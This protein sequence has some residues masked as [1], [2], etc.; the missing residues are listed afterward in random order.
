MWWNYWDTCITSERSYYTRLNYIHFNPVKHG[1]VTQTEDYPFS[2]HTGYLRAQPE[3]IRRI[4]ANY[5][6]DRVKVKDDF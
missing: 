1:I 5:P 3:A 4:I 2:S 6:F